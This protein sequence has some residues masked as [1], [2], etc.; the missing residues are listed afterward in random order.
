MDN[1]KLSQITS[2]SIPNML[3]LCFQ[4]LTVSNKIKILAKKQTN[5]DKKI[6]KLLKETIKPINYINP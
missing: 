1:D 2:Y 5:T 4:I 3:S 6:K